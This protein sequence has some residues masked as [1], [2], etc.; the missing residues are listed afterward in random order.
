MEGCS[1]TAREGVLED[2]QC[3]TETPFIFFYRCDKQ[4]MRMF[5]VYLAD[6]VINQ[7]FRRGG[8]GYSGLSSHFLIKPL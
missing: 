1:L 3:S 2:P 7:E 4:S 5:A 8:H 6:D